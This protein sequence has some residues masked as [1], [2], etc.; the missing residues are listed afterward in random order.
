MH[1]ALWRIRAQDPSQHPQ[2]A[3]GASPE[4][5]PPAPGGGGGGGAAIMPLPAR[6]PLRASPLPQQASAP[7]PQ[8]Q[9]PPQRTTRTGGCRRAASLPTSCP[10]TTHCNRGS[11]GA[12][13]T[14]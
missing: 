14:D 2:L 3:E 7:Q 6:A 1:N 13:P 12:P 5:P 4:G 8:V 10:P 11:S 9:P